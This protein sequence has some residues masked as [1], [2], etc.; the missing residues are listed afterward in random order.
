MTWTSE[1]HVL[2]VPEDPTDYLD[3]EHPETCPQFLETEV[4]WTQDDAYACQVE[5][6][7][8]NVG[9]HTFFH[10]PGELGDTYSTEVEPGRYLI[11]SYVEIIRGPEG[12]EY[13]AGLALYDGPDFP[14][15]DELDVIEA[16]CE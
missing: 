6:H 12:N 13:N 9:A 11:A 10:R 16:D 2:V 3:V 5:W 15:L 1:P 8:D 14:D 7:L 4:I